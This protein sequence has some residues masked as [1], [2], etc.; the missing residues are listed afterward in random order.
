[1]NNGF[2]TNFKSDSLQN[3]VSGIPTTDIGYLLPLAYVYVYCN[4]TTPYP[5]ETTFYNFQNVTSTTIPTDTSGIGYYICYPPGVIN[6][7]S[8]GALG[9]FNI[10]INDSYISNLRGICVGNLYTPT[11]NGALYFFSST[12]FP[13]VIFDIGPYTNTFNISIN[14]NTG[15]PTNQ[16]FSFI[17]Y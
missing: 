4:N 11:N 2:I 3:E 13:G 7:V 17:L 8:I 10:G 6:N 12:M 14:D 15:S 9:V 5:Y 1:M 16:S